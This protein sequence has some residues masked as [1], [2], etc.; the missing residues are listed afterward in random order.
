M[1]YRSVKHINKTKLGHLFGTSSYL[2]HGCASHVHCRMQN[3]MRVGHYYEPMPFN[4]AV[5]KDNIY[6]CILR[7]S[8]GV[9]YQHAY[10]LKHMQLQ[11][12]IAYSGI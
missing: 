1:D 2:S 8:Y 7:W 10:D 5:L 9:K 6:P 4:K 11:I 3:F 12:F